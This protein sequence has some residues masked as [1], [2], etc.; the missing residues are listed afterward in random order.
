VQFEL[1][2]IGGRKVPLSAILY[3]PPRAMFMGANRM[4]FLKLDD[5]FIGGTFF[6]NDVHLR[7]KQLDSEWITVTPGEENEKK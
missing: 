5:S 2:E 6:F 7:A 1:V 4:R 3:P